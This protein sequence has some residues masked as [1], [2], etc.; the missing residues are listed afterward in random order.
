MAIA[1]DAS[2][3]GH[4]SGATSLTVSHT[5]TGSAL[6]LVVFIKIDTGVTFTGITYNSVAM[7]FRNKITHALDYD[8]LCYYLANPST[9]AH[10]IVASWTGSHAAEMAGASYTGVRQGTPIYDLSDGSTADTGDHITQTSSATTVANEV[11]VGMFGYDSY[12]TNY[13]TFTVASS[14]TQRASDALSNNNGIFLFDITAATATTYSVGG[15]LSGGGN[16]V[17]TLNFIS[18][19]P[20]VIDTMSVSVGS[21]TLTGINVLLSVAHRIVA[22]VQ[23]YTLTGIDV[24]LHKKIIYTLT[25]AVQTYLLTG[26][27]VRL[28]AFLNRFTNRTKPITTWTNRDKT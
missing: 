6:A 1:F 16:G 9:G 14:G 18:L 25:T 22:T 4:T 8:I 26:V 5:C 13:P 2:S 20:P 27:S 3:S 11:I 19:L 10:N 23:T 28:H 7:T 12:S 15:T 24:L 21:F 17:L